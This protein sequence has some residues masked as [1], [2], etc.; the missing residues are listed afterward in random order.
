MNRKL[1]STSRRA[2]LKWGLCSFG[3]PIPFASE[4]FDGFATKDEVLALVG[5]I[6]TEK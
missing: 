2:L 1:S 5:P 4:A 3:S 6:L